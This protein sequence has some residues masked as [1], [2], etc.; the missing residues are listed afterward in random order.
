M[1]DIY[2]EYQATASGARIDQYCQANSVRLWRSGQSHEYGGSI[3]GRPFGFHDRE[4]SGTIPGMR[5]ES[6][7]DFRQFQTWT[8]R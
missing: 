8:A 1:S 4:T 5:A 7:V 6:I 2:V 3:C